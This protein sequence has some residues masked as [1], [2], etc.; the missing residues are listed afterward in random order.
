MQRKRL[1]KNTVTSL[2]LQ[3]ITVL[4]GIILPRQI[5]ES[6]GSEVNGLVNSVT[7]FL[8]VISFLELGVGAVVQTALYQP[9]AENDTK[10][11]SEIVASA[12]RFFHHLGRIFLV[13]IAALMCVYPL[14][15][16]QNFGWIYSAV[17]IAVMSISTI[18]QYYF[19]IVDRLLLLANQQGYIH[20]TAQIVTLIL[21]TM[22]CIF[23]IRLNISIHIV[24]LTT[25]FI[26]LLRP[27]VL[28]LYINHHYQIDRHI[29]YVGEPI[30]QKWNGIAQHIAAV[31]LDGTDI[32][33]LTAFSSFSNVS[34][35]SVY[36]FVVAGIKQL[37][38]SLTNG[39]HALIG[40][41]WAKQ[42]LL[43]LHKTFS[44]F[45]WTL[46]SV[47]V[48]VFGCAGVL[49]LPFVS[50]YTYNICDANY[51]QPLFAMFIVLANAGHCLRLP[52]NTMILAAGHFKQTQSNY[53]IAAILNIVI[54][55]A[56][57]RRWGLV[58]VAIGT[59]AAMAYQTVWMAYYNSRNLLYWP[60]KNFCKQLAVDGLTVLLAVPVCRLLPLS[61][62][63]YGQWVLCAIP[64]AV[65]WLVSA[66]IVN[67]IFYRE[68]LI[69]LFGR[70]LRILKLRG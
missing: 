46:H 70:G 64:V 30:R 17:L 20:Y 21:N 59:L 60:F 27:L 15:A 2:L 51:L 11:S 9:L 66:L 4:C 57:V 29:Q 41:L 62:E 6:Y 13:Y 61:A 12:T 39:I 55:V 38:M 58:G 40:E 47:T 36:H 19:G 37:L 52:Y 31:V 3:I 69:A 68:K 35:Y 8:S 42:D 24:K 32:I 25:S 53:I 33:V 7:Q 22:S 28:R 34:I 63:N 16:R 1:A 23:L 45:E 50:I 65:V 56:A 5:L 67:L 54:S 10:K 26:Y 49:I 14:L 48:V 44:W 43:K 18:A